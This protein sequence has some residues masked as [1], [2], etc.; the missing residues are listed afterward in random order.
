MSLTW[1][2]HL[3][4]YIVT[5]LL[6]Y[7][8]CSRGIA[9][10]ARESFLVAP[11][12]LHNKCFFVWH[13]HVHITE[14]TV[15]TSQ[16]MLPTHVILQCW[17]TTVTTTLQTISERWRTQLFQPIFMHLPIISRTFRL[18]LLLLQ[19]MQ[20]LFSCYHDTLLLLQLLFLSIRQCT[21]LIHRW[22]CCRACWHL[23]HLT[24]TNKVYTCSCKNS[25]LN[26]FKM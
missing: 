21:Q 26:T 19:V 15:N 16:Y 10:F 25:E 9:V 23:G 17:L 7:L 6:T 1:Q 12:I 18:L 4:Q 11:C 14:R 22:L 20:A 3:N 2:C 8:R 5:F 24:T 13:S